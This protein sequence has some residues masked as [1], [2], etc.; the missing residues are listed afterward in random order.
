MVRLFRR[1]PA[2]RCDSMARERQGV[3]RLG[4]KQAEWGLLVTSPAAAQGNP[5]KTGR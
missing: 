2:F 4:D 3:H 1:R 5:P